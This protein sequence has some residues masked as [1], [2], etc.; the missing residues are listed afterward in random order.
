[1]AKDYLANCS[2]NL[3]FTTAETPVLKIP[4][5]YACPFAVPDDEEE[6]DQYICSEI[7]RQNIEWVDKDGFDDFYRYPMLGIP[8]P[9]PLKKQPTIICLDK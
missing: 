7:A 9:C 6:S 3:T 8:T 2:P 4:G 1:M 5:C